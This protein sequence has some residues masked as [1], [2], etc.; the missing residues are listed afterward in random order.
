MRT[1][2]I[3]K[4]RYTIKAAGS[5][6]TGNHTVYK[7]VTGDSNEYFLIEFRN[8]SG[9]DKGLQDVLGKSFGGLAIW[10]VDDNIL[11]NSVDSHRLVD[12]EEADKTEGYGSKTDLWYSGNGVRFTTTSSPNNKRYDKMRTN[13]CVDRISK[14]GKKAMTAALGC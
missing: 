8:T 11:H 3:K 6:A 14:A 7:S 9:Y 4:G 5:S 1:K 2:T 12:L 13:A 10:H